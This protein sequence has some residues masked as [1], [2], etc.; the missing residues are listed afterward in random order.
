MKAKTQ[1]CWLNSIWLILCGGLVCTACVPTD[2]VPTDFAPTEPP[3][4]TMPPVEETTV[5]REVFVYEDANANGLYNGNEGERPLP[6]VLITSHS[7]IHGT[8]ERLTQWTSDAGDAAFEA[9]FTHYFDLYVVP[10]C[11]Y[12]PTTPVRRDATS[13]KRISFGLAPDHPRTGDAIVRFFLW[14]DENQD[15]QQN[16]GELPFSGTSLQITLSEGDS[17]VEDVEQDALAITTDA[18]GWGEINLGNSCGRLDLWPQWFQPWQFREWK[19]ASTDPQPVVVV[20]DW[21]YESDIRYYGFNYDVGETVIQ[22]GLMENFPS[23]S[24]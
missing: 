24:P 22:V 4:S 14:K 7:N 9:T 19:I 5:S 6:H 10:L 3:E 15:G 11:G 18:N 16:K 21:T 8:D 23:N 13:S 2:V 1:K 12:M 17:P 20:H